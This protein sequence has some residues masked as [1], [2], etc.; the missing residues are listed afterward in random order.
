MA[1]YSKSIGEAIILSGITHED[2]GDLV[3]VSRQTV[4][5]WVNGRS[6]PSH[7]I[8]SKVESVLGYISGAVR[9]GKLPMQLP[10]TRDAVRERRLELLRAALS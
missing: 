1:A 9:A 4:C 3:G 2:F 6:E 5:K 7:L 8:T 10:D